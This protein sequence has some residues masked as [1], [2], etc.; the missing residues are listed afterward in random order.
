MIPERRSR[1]NSRGRHV[2]FDLAKLSGILGLLLWLGQ[3]SSAIRQTPHSPS[4]PPKPFD[5]KLVQERFPRVSFGMR[6]EEVFDLFGP[7]HSTRF[8]EPEFDT[9]EAVAR[10]RP[11]RY[12]GEPCWAK[13]SD[14]E[15]EDKWVAVFFS[16][17]YVRQTFKKGF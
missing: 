11:D 5:F 1:I 13:W 3:V 2:L 12:P 8:W 7:E 15:D 4:P 6:I 16:G 14:P 17:G 10:V 9:T